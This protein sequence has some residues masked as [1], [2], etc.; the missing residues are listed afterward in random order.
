MGCIIREKNFYK[1]KLTSLEKVDTREIIK[2]GFLGMLPVFEQKN[3]E[4]IST[5]LSKR[6]ADG[7][8]LVYLS[9]LCASPQ[10][11]YS[12]SCPNTQT[13]H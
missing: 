11:A 13:Y 5:A 8:S 2:L 7:A 12:N 6:E 10:T 9:W 3:L 1:S 4:E